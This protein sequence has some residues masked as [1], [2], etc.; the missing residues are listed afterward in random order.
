MK[1]SLPGSGYGSGL[2]TTVSIHAKIAELNEEHAHLLRKAQ[3]VL[4]KVEAV[5][6][7]L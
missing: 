5:Q 3:K 6:S 4:Q 7:L 1:T 2:S